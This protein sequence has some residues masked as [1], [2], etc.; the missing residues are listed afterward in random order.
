MNITADTTAVYVMPDGAVYWYGFL[1]PITGGFMTT[2]PNL[3][4]ANNEIYLTVTGGCG[5]YGSISS[6]VNGINV[7]DNGYTKFKSIANA[8]SS[9]VLSIS[10]VV[11]LITSPHGGKDD[12][13]VSF[14]GA[15][16]SQSYYNYKEST[17][18]QTRSQDIPSGYEIT[19]PCIDAGVNCISGPT[20]VTLHVKAM[21][22]E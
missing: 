21:W 11:G 22:Y 3:N 2:D 6:T 19:Y 13:H 12:S 8:E 16:S 1:N 15:K 14:V 10:A 9:N 5:S 4:F 7:L 18:Y 20:A 17:T